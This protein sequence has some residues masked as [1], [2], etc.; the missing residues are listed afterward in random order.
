MAAPGLIAELREAWRT[1]PVKLAAVAGVISGSLATVISANPTLAIGMLAL[2]PA[3][4]VMYLLGVVVAATVFL[5]P[6]LT[7]I[8]HTVRTRPAEPQATDGE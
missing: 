7:Q 5:I 6:T 4:P 3:G 8:V 1:G 2:M